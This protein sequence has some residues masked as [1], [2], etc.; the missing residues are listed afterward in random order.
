MHPD[1]IQLFKEVGQVLANFRS[2][3][4][5]K[6]FKVIPTMLNWEQILEY[7]LLNI[8]CICTSN[9]IHLKTNFSRKL[10]RGCHVS[11]NQTVCGDR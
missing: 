3:K 10:V 11:G 4:V 9:L 1:V 6:A 7:F 2:G 8:I 5:P